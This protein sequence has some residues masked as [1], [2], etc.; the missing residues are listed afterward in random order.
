MHLLL[1]VPVS[2]INSATTFD[3][4]VIIFFAKTLGN[5]VIIGTILY[6]F[7]RPMGRTDVFASI[8]NLS[9]KLLDFFVVA[10][11]TCATFT[12]VFLLKAYF[13]IPRPPVFDT[14]LKALLAQT[15]FGF[16]SSH[17]AVFMALA[18]SLFFV[19]RKAGYVTL[20]LAIA[21]GIA[22]VLA[23]VHTPLDIIGGF[24]VGSMVAIIVDF[25]AF[26]VLRPAKQEN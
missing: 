12:L 14:G 21:I 7:F 1:M 22:R 15:D 19:S 23:G 5:L 26:E 10:I 8:E 11:S 20:A 17:A 9:E 18:V 24:V 2:F 6:L 25:L 16:P 4:A 13:K 3:I